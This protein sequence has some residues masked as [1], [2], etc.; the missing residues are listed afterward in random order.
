MICSS[1]SPSIVCDVLRLDQVVALDLAGL[2]RLQ[3]GGVVGDRP[4]D[5]GVDRRLVAPVVVVLDQRELVV[6][7]PRVEL[8]RAR[9]D[10]VL[11]AERPGRGE[12]AVCVGGALVGLELRQ[13][14]RAGDREGLLREGRNECGR[15]LGQRQDRS[16]RVCRLAARVEAVLRRA[17]VLVVGLEAAEDDLPV[18]G[19]AR[20]LERTLEVVPAVEVEA[21][22]FGV[23]RL[24]VVERHSFADLERPDLAGVVRRPA[25]GET[26]LHLGRAGLE[27]DE[28]LEDLRD[29]TDRLA[30]GDDR[31]VERDRV[32]RTREDQRPAGLTG[33]FAGCCPCPPCL[34]VIAAAPCC[35]DGQHGDDE[36]HQQPVPLDPQNVSFQKLPGSAGVSRGPPRSASKPGRRRAAG[37]RAFAQRS[38][39]SVRG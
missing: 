7:G 14:L 38:L 9:A 4:K 21:D 8:Q 20:V 32:G 22:R 13:R 25:L 1:A 39:A 19:R 2:Q 27:R 30:V 23:E 3:A 37:G 36:Q 24:A 11:G 15:R 31:P 5:Q 33:G 35:R 34:I 16:S 28:R 10:R 26:G 29:R 12:D 18:V 17:A 6:T